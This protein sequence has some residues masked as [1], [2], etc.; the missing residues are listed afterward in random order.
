VAVLGLVIVVGFAIGRSTVAD[1]LPAEVT[2]SHTATSHDDSTPCV[3]RAECAGAW[4]FG[5]AALLL[6]VTVTAPT[7]G[8]VTTVSRLRTF[9][10]TL[11]S[12]IVASRL[13]RPPQFS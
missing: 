9:P 2:H 4:A 3:L 11:T 12:A 6:V 10:R 1:R 8:A 5:T 13:E 7:I